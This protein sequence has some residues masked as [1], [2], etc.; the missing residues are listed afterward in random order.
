MLKQLLPLLLPL[1]ILTG[2][3]G[4]GIGPT[5]ANLLPIN[6]VIKLEQDFTGTITI[7]EDNTIL[8]LNGYTVHGTSW[9]FF[10][11]DPTGTCVNVRA[12][13]VTIKNG[14]IGACLTGINIAS[15]FARGTHT[16]E[17]TKIW[18]EQGDQAA[19]NYMNSFYGK[20]S[21]NVWI[22]NMEI[23]PIIHGIYVQPYIQGTKISATSVNRGRIGVY[24]DSGNK[25]TIINETSFN[26]V[27][28]TKYVS[29]LRK[30]ISRSAGEGREAIAADGVINLTVRNSTFTNSNLAGIAV[31]RNCMED[32]DSTSTYPRLIGS[33]GMVFTNNVFNDEDIGIWLGSRQQRDLSGWDCGA[34]P[35][36]GGYYMDYASNTEIR[37]NTFNRTDVAVEVAGD[38]N[39]VLDNT[40]N[41]AVILTTPKADDTMPT[42]VVVQK[43]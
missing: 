25:D 43:Q 37:F 21:D 22:K 24:L 16:V 1:V 31:Y 26:D 34:T 23:T 18:Q 8:D 2:C 10:D 19:N 11:N 36:A 5:D 17:A 7:R 3:G 29:S 33:K 38:N 40:L 6:G 13:N 14:K 41:G 42:G 9:G 12:K 20:G 4:G 27:G 35:E 28:W 39:T 32:K 30:N 15:G